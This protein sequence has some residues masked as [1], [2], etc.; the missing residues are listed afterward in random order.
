MSI[1]RGNQNLEWVLTLNKKSVFAEPNPSAT[2]SFTKGVTKIKVSSL[3]I[4]TSREHGRTHDSTGLLV[5]N[6]Q[7]A[8]EKLK[9]P[10]EL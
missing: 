2:K 4:V 6:N 7:L 5:L 3:L 1:K 10:L 8:A 9:Y